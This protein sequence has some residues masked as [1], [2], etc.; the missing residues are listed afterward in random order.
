MIQH[1]KTFIGLSDSDFEAE[2]VQ[3][4]L[5]FCIDGNLNPRKDLCFPFTTQQMSGK[6]R[7]K[8]WLSLVLRDFFFFFPSDTHNKQLGKE[9]GETL[10]HVRF[11]EIKLSVQIFSINGLSHCYSQL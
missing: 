5:S 10:E 6:I 8:I 7:T 3:L 11:V 1:L 9:A 4:L 2:I